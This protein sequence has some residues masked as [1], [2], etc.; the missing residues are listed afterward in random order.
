MCHS[1]VSWHLTM[2]SVLILQI[3]IGFIVSPSHSLKELQF[4]Q[5]PYKWIRYAIGVV[6]GAEGHLSSSSYSCDIVDYSTELPD[7][8]VFLYYHTS[9]EERQRMFPLYPDLAHTNS[10]SSIATTCRAHFRDEV[11]ERDGQTCVIIEMAAVHC[12]LY[13]TSQSRPYG[14]RYCTKH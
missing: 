9:D 13:S 3:G 14:R 10:T 4:S 12:Y 2:A 6:I 11:A 5:R 1:L 7:E 8:S